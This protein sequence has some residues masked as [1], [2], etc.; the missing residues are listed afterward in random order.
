VAAARSPDLADRHAQQQRRLPVR[1]LFKTLSTG[2]F[3]AQ[4]LA[5]LPS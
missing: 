3:T 2:H 1:C 5:D 4:A